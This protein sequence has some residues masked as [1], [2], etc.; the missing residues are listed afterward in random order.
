MSRT[1]ARHRLGSWL[2]AGLGAWCTVPAQDLPVPQGVLTTFTVRRDEDR[3]SVAANRPAMPCDRALRELASALGW[4]LRWQVDALGE[5]LAGEI[6]DLAFDDLEP[7]AAA[8]LIAVAGGADVVVNQRND[9]LGRVQVDLVVVEVPDA[10]TEVGRARLRRSAL[11][12][13]ERFLENSERA[14]D[15]DA[16]EAVD[17][18]IDVAELLRGQG[19]LEA[20]TRVLEEAY[21][22]APHAASIPTALLRMAECY[23]ELGSSYYA[24]CERRARELTRLHPGRPEAVRAT[25]LLGRLLLAQARYEECISELG[26]RS[27]YVAGNPEVVDVYLLLARAWFRLDRPTESASVLATLDEAWKA[28]D[29]STSQRADHAFLRGAVAQLLGRHREAVRDLER[30]FELVDEEHADRPVAFVALGDAY[31]AGERYLQAR[32]AAFAAR[33]TGRG[34]DGVWARRSS[35]LWARTMLALGDEE[36]AFLELEVEVRKDPER[37]AELALFLAARLRERGRYQK[38]VSVLERIV[39]RGDEVGDR[40]RLETIEALYEQGLDTGSLHGFPE[41]ARGLA[42]KISSTELQRR[43]AELFGQAYDALGDIERAADAWRGVI[44]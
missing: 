15:P 33:E 22:L 21:A 17:A 23:L 32:A 37:E 14:A 16:V 27:L 5:Q 9:D 4:R 7:R 13:Y 39:G 36:R 29:M 2:V 20:A 41:Q 25:V 12:W 1:D 11:D 31:L 40:A 6:V 30:Y 8:Q 28:V 35:E 3:V 24:E 10:V 38:A 19:E 18:R 43:V 34:L 26:K 44:R 42:A